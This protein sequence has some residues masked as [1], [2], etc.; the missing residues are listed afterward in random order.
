MVCQ[1]ELLLKKLKFRFINFS[2]FL[3]WW[4]L[5]K[6]HDCWKSTFIV[7]KTF[8]ASHMYIM[9]MVV[10]TDIISFIQVFIL[11]YTISVV[12][13]FFC[14]FNIIIIIFLGCLWLLLKIIKYFF[15]ILKSLFS[16]FLL[17]F[18]IIKLR[19]FWYIVLL[20]FEWRFRVFWPLFDIFENYKR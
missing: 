6:I 1:I 20:G 7:C 5:S 18:V 10:N 16:R 14:S 3:S 17:F 19:I 15:F 11:F 4:K 9:C 13:F 12:F 2:Y 8:V